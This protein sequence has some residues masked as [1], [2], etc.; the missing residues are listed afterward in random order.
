MLKASSDR[1]PPPYRPAIPAS[2][3]TAKPGA[4][5][6]SR[7]RA[8]SDDLAPVMEELHRWGL[9]VEVG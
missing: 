4:L 3:S 2:T 7:G 6:F 5:I 8:V 9:S 1:N